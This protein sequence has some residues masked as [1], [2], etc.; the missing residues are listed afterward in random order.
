MIAKL[1]LII[2]KVM[3]HD[4]I[5]TNGYGKC[6]IE[7]LT[8]HGVLSKTTKEESKYRLILSQHWETKSILLCLD[9]LSL[10]CHRGFCNKLIKFPISFKNIYQQSLIFQKALP[11]Y[12]KT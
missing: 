11:T 9:G 6:I 5:S 3:I 1:S 12:L 2:P 4:E 10:G 8:I 7:L